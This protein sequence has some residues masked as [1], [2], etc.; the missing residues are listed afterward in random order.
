MTD[1]DIMKI[2]KMLDDKNVPTKDRVAFFIDHDIE[3]YALEPSPLNDVK[4][5]IADLIEKLNKATDEAISEFVEVFHL[6]LP[7]LANNGEHIVRF[8]GKGGQLHEYYYNGKLFL[9]AHAQKRIAKHWEEEG[10]TL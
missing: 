5:Q 9:T 8:D 3:K 7:D 10:W 6:T 2:V 4:K 1:D